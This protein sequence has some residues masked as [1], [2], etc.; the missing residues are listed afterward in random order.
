MKRKQ[1]TIRP[2]LLIIL[3]VTVLFSCFGLSLFSSVS[4][5]APVSYGPWFPKPGTGSSGIAYQAD[6]KPF[7]DNNI[8]EIV[9]F[10]CVMPN[11]NPIGDTYDDQNLL[12]D[13]NRYAA[14]VYAGNLEEGDFGDNFYNEE[15][16]ENLGFQKGQAGMKQWLRMMDQA[17][18]QEYVFY[19]LSDYMEIVPKADQPNS[20]FRSPGDSEIGFRWDKSDFESSGVLLGEGEGNNVSRSQFKKSRVRLAYLLN[21]QA[22]SPLALNDKLPEGCLVSALNPLAGLNLNELFS[23]DLGEQSMNILF[24]II[25]KPVEAIYGFVAPYAFKYTFWTPHSERGDLLWTTPDGCDFKTLGAS[26]LKKTQTSRSN[27]CNSAGEPLGFNKSRTDVNKQNSLYLNAARMIQWLVSGLYFLILFT[28]AVLFIFKGNRN[29]SFNVL[30]VLPRLVLA[31]ILTLFSGFIIGAVISF[32]NL[33]VQMIFET[34]GVSTVGTVNTILQQAGPIVG[35]GEFVERLINLVAS[36]LAM[37]YYIVFILTVAL[38]QIVLIVLVIVAPLAFLSLINPKWE[39][40]FWKWIRALLAVTAIP[41]LA[42]L[43]LKISL[44]I[45]PLVLDPQGSFG[46]VQ[47]LLGIIILLITL[48]LMTKLMKSGRDFIFGQSGT[49]T[50][51]M[52]GA[53]SGSDDQ[54]DDNQHYNQQGAYG[55]R[56]LNS[57][58]GPAYKSSALIPEGRQMSGGDHLLTSGANSASSAS[59]SNSITQVKQQSG[60]TTDANAAIV[61]FIDKRKGVN[62]SQTVDQ[63]NKQPP[64]LS[65]ADDSNIYSNNEFKKRR[66]AR[67]GDDSSNPFLNESYGNKL[68]DLNFSAD[69]F[70]NIGLSDRQPLINVGGKQ[71]ALAFIEQQEN[72]YLAI[73]ESSRALS[74]LNG[75]SEENPIAARE[76]AILGDLK[77]KVESSEYK[78]QM[79]AESQMANI[80]GRES[81][82]DFTVEGDDYIKERVRSA[83]RGLEER[84]YNQQLSHADVFAFNRF[85]DNMESLAGSQEGSA[86]RQLLDELAS[87]VQHI[88]DYDSDHFN[89]AT[90]NKYSVLAEAAL[91]GDKDQKTKEASQEFKQRKEMLTKLA[92]VRGVAPAGNIVVV[93]DAE[94][95]EHLRN[96]GQV[97]EKK[98]PQ[99]AQAIAHSD[100]DLSGLV[101]I[102]AENIKNIKNNPQQQATVVHEFIH[103]TQLENRSGEG[104]IQTSLTEAITEALTQERTGAKTG[105]YQ[106]E[107]SKLTEILSIA[108]IEKDQKDDL[109][110]YLS[111]VD[112][113]R[114]REWLN[115]RLKEVGEEVSFDEMWQETD[116][117]FKRKYQKE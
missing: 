93:P 59:D 22:S 71:Q 11:G 87:R 39:A 14:K 78:D 9:S 106:E 15:L 21:D 50:G 110:S 113:E 27:Y 40:N 43:L 68:K 84:G 18:R 103:Q 36:A 53:S 35:G 44:S 63:Q 55:P 115:H 52:N 60:D 45:N 2:S 13:I 101:V 88:K 58:S 49:A 83:R 48:Y 26:P 29:N 99:E 102:P 37:I 7:N 1:K 3:L 73:Q 30:H 19:P 46:N 79:I 31:V 94:W 12:S 98:S 56:R 75:T 82:H 80:I 4:S 77:K 42:A 8:S 34:N 16:P 91:A 25:G 76:L 5:A 117:E 105:G 65:P 108:K 116:E 107:V 17:L 64:V 32:S 41:V 96:H 10:A 104:E 97:K 109:L 72:H 86:P 100:S 74:R 23:G 24:Y 114:R 61:D 89:S 70:N 85:L 51:M 54:F 33:L 111:S 69:Q 57:G 95:F 112:P 47:G 66:S 20:S 38:R 67:R 90:L 6:Y 28:S 81:N 62:A 92:T